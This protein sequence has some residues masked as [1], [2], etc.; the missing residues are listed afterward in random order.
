MQVSVE[1]IKGL[2]RKMTVSIPSA[3]IESAVEKKLNSIKNTVKIDG[4]R[5][6]KVPA[7]VVKKHYGGAIRSDVLGEVIQSS[8]GEALAKEG[9][10]PA[11]NPSIDLAEE[12]TE[13]KDFTY[14]AAFEVYPKISLA[15]SS[16]FKLEKPIVEISTADVDEM[17]ENLRTQHKTW[18]KVDRKS[19]NGDQVSISFVGTIDG[20]EFE[21]GKADDIQVV[22]GSSSMIDGFEKGLLGL[23]NGTDTILNLKFP[24][25]Y[26]K[27][28]LN[29]KK[30]K[31][32]VTVNQV[33]EEVLPEV[34]AEFA[35]KFGIKDGDIKALKQQIKTN[36][37]RERIQ[38]IR[39]F[40]KNQVTE[41]LHDNNKNIEIP[42]AL[43]EQE[44]QG[45]LDNLKRQMQGSA[46][47]D[48]LIKPETMKPEAERRVRLSLVMGEILDKNKISLDNK[49][50]KDF[51][52]AEAASY[53]DSKQ[54]IDYYMNNDE[55]LNSI[56]PLVLEQQVVEYVMD[57]AT[58]KEVE[59]KFSELV[60]KVNPQQG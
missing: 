33:A 22:L 54:F 18:A 10:K 14:T 57:E 45:M 44:V 56:K 29:G 4:F 48:D 13:G 15:D 30:V 43:I 21:G 8:Y 58:V 36:M 35:K 40:V 50:L 23:A 12:E 3:D 16:K 5:P 59:L 24:D 2:Q 34:N 27:E 17:I 9:L 52:E 20:K 47:I 60:D 53:E 41:A 1:T 39:Q 31:F 42:A 55:A 6:G 11:G 26:Q 51:I 38:Y 28:D 32:A 37:E 46:N 49:K 19:K 7:A 25:D